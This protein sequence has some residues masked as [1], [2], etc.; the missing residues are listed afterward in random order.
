MKM[1]CC[2]K[3]L[4]EGCPATVAAKSNNPPVIIE[5]TPELAGFVL[6]QL[7]LE[8]GNRLAV[9]GDGPT[10]ANVRRCR[11]PVGPYDRKL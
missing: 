11:S 8:H 10:I 1:E 7:Q 3:A 6:E 2:G 4:C 9:V 5:L